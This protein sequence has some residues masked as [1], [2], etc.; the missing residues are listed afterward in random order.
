MTSKMLRCV[1]C[2]ELISVTEYDSAPE[3]YYNENIKDFA[4]RPRDDRKTFKLKHRGHKLEELDVIGGSYISQWPYVEPVKEGFF[5][6]TN[7]K[8]IFLVRKWRDTINDPV[9]YELIGGDIKII[10]TKPEIQY[11]DI[12][13]QIMAEIPSMTNK[14][15]DRFIQA[16]EDVVSRLD[17][18]SLEVSAEG[19]GP[20]IIYYKLDD[21]NI[22]QILKKISKIFDPKKSKKIKQF[23]HQNMDHNDVM[24]LKVRKRF[25]I[26]STPKAKPASPLN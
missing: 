1:R 15:I 14:H 13:K 10:D 3:Y 25:K 8:E 7:G 26:V 20:S 18:E 24:T 22:R 17:W 2:N 16:V 11:Q 23:I 9:S 5:H 21:R 6:V 12:R 19:E 4:E